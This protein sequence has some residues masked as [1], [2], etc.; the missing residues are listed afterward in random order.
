MVA[1]ERARARREE[2]RWQP[3][4]RM[5]PRAG[6]RETASLAALS[7]WGLRLDAAGSIRSH[8]KMVEEVESPESG[9][10]EPLA[11]SPS[12]A[13]AR[14]PVAWGELSVVLLLSFVPPLAY[15]YLP[16]LTGERSEGTHSLSG[17]ITWLLACIQVSVPLL[18][19]LARTP[20][21]LAHFGVFRLRLRDD[22]GWVLFLFAAGI[23]LYLAERVLDG[24]WGGELTDSA[25]G[26]ALPSPWFFLIWLPR[27]FF[28]A[29]WEELGMRAYLLTRFREWG[30][31][32]GW[33]ALL[34]SA[35]FASYHVYQGF[36][37][38]PSA[39]LFGLL[40]SLAYLRIGRVAPLVVAHLLHNSAMYAWP[41]LLPAL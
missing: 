23:L 24:S 20:E 13:P 10:E 7:R 11:A 27:I 25:E 29:L 31:G 17:E 2:R 22:V 6:R 15:A 8:A 18:W 19:I 26:V 16:Y 1:F 32:W 40:Y 39:F 28:S 30:L 34:A 21:G 41:Y 36:E 5:I 37:A 14:A 35:M 38:L 3:V 12:R 33:A 4:V 9:G